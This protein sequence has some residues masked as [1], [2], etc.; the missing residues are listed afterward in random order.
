MHNASL[1]NSP[2]LQQQQLAFA[3]SIRDPLNNPAMAGVSTERMALYHELFYN[4]FTETLSAA[5]PVLRQ[6]LDVT[7]WQPLCQQ[8][9]EQHTCATPYLVRMPGEF[10]D[11][12]RQCHADNPPWLLELAFWEW[13]ELE[14]LLAPDPVLPGQLNTDV[15]HGIPMLSPLL[16]MHAFDFAVHKICADY[17]PDMPD[18]QKNYLAAWRK[19]DD[20]IAFMQVNA[21]SFRLLQLLKDN[22]QQTGFELLSIIANDQTDFDS[23]IIVRGGTEILQSFYQKGIL[24]GALYL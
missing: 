8:F 19:A 3:A 10:V 20:T 7:H 12:L 11:F 2:I 6:V 18:A 1:H 21:F 9:F 14:L 22:Q 5:F 4:N 16:R 15:L 13:T 17:L 23:T 24:L